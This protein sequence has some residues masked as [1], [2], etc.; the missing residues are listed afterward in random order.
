VRVCWNCNRQ[1]SVP[2]VARAMNTPPLLPEDIALGD[3]APPRGKVD[4]GLTNSHTLWRAYAGDGYQ[5][6]PQKH[7]RTCCCEVTFRASATPCTRASTG[8][9]SKTA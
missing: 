6:G 7:L 8:R 2:T 1:L 5:D 4:F 3:P 9:V